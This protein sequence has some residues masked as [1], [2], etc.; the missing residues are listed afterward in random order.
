MVGESYFMF[1]KWV[2]RG[3]ENLSNKK[4]ENGTS[5]TKKWY[6]VA[7]NYWL[8]RKGPLFPISGSLNRGWQSVCKSPI[9]LCAFKK[10]YSEH[11]VKLSKIKKNIRNGNK[12]NSKSNRNAILQYYVYITENIHMQIRVLLDIWST[13][14]TF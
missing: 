6:P 4:C 12:K 10:L 5:E 11:I 13:Y 14:V 3:C 2:L 8:S 1:F 9:I 7:C